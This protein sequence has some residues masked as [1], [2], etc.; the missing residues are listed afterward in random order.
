MTAPGSRKGAWG[1]PRFVHSATPLPTVPWP[2]TSLGQDNLTGRRVGK[3]TVVGLSPI[4]TGGGGARWVVQCTCGA[5]EHRNTRFI[6][7][8]RAAGAACMKC[9]EWPDPKGSK[10]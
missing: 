7:T 8:G 4:G 1:D 5:Y 9:A 10:A 2:S 3:L 6:R